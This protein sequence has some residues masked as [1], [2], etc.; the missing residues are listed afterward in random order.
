[1]G[2]NSYFKEDFMKRKMRG[3]L[4]L[5]AVAAIMV[6]VLTTAA[7]ADDVN[8]ALDKPTLGTPYLEPYEHSRANDGDIDAPSMFHSDTSAGPAWWG[9]DLGQQYAIGRIEVVMRQDQAGNDGIRSGF[10]VYGSNDAT[11]ATRTLLAQHDIASPVPAMGTWT[12]NISNTGT[13]RYLRI[14][15]GDT[16]PGLV[17]NEFRA[18]A[19]EVTSTP[20]PTSG[21]ENPT[22]TTGQG[23]STPTQT[24]DNT[25][26]PGDAFSIGMALIVL[27]S[28]GTVFV[29][30]KRRLA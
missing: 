16:V 15:R 14:D 17:I 21:T 28:L 27:L 20:A 5:F 19:K 26:N 18:F 29:V 25:T 22:P 1:L 8:I 9:V 2:K 4:T 3:V 6:S 13:Y 10:F 24:P 30:S 23:T 7:F 11:F 12:V